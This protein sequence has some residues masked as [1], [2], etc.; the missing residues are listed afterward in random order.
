[1]KLR[2][3]PL[4]LAAGL[5]AAHFLRTYSLAPMLISLAAPLLL[6]VKRPWSLRL[7]Q[8]L[9]VV[10]TLIWMATLYGI[11]Q[12]RNLE[13]RSWAA[14]GVILGLVA[15]F[16]LYAGWLM[17]SSLVKSAYTPAPGQ[18]TE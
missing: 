3:A 11:I 17:N 18:P 15:A 12:Q 13:G 5:L 10:A 6:L 14:S 7:L 1:M 8:A 9:T 4:L 2:I 16:T